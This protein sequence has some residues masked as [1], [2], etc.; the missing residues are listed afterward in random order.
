VN[1]TELRRHLQSYLRQ[2]QKGG[3][4]LI[5]SHGKTIARLAPARDEDEMEAARR[6]LF[7]LR[8][9]SI[10]GDVIDPIED[11]NWTADADHL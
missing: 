10:L 9:K 5:T 1:V 2:V 4:I 6:R 7:A 11:V 3:E 8:D